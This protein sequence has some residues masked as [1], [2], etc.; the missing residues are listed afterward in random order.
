MWKMMRKKEIFMPKQCMPLQSCLNFCVKLVKELHRFYCKSTFVAASGKE[1]LVPVIV[2]LPNLV[3]RQSLE[4]LNA[5]QRSISAESKRLPLQY[6]KSPE[7]LWAKL[8][9]LEN[10][11]S[12]TRYWEPC[13]FMFSFMSFPDS[14]ACVQHIISAVPVV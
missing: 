5:H 14:S 6:F 1:D 2:M 9:E 10:N 12:S 8:N 7:L 11:L 4:E 3:D 13:T